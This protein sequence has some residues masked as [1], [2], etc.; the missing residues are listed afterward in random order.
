MNSERRNPLPRVLV[1]AVLLAAA[2][3]L[4]WHTGFGGPYLDVGSVRTPTPR[5]FVMAAL[6]AFLGIPFV[7]CVAAAA[8][9]L[10]PAPRLERARATWLGIPQRSFLALAALLGTLLPLLL[11]TLLLDHA[12]ITDDEASYRF[13]AELLASGHLWMPSPPMKLFYDNAFLVND[14]KLRSQYFLGWPFL[15]A[16]GV[17]LGVPSLINPL[18]SGA[19]VAGVFLVARRWWGEAWARVAAVLFLL[20]PFLLVGAA[21]GMSHPT[22]LVALVWLLVAATHVDEKASPWVS[23]GAALCI[24]LA[25]WA[26]PSVAVG[27]GLPF[28]VLW[29]VQAWRSGARGRH[30]AAFAAVALPLAAL[31]LW[32]NQELNGSPWLTGYQASARYAVANGFRFAP[33]SASALKNEGFLFFFDP[34]RFPE[35]VGQSVTALFR[36]NVDA[37]GWPFSLALVLLARSRQAR[38]LAAAVVSNLL[39]HLPVP[40]AG[41]DSFGPVHYYEL[42]LPVVLLSTDGLRTLWRW[43]ADHQVP[44]LAPAVLAGLVAACVLMYLPPRWLTLGRLVQ[45]INAPRELVER[46]APAGAVIFAPRSMAPPCRSNPA[47]HFVFFRPNSGPGFDDD[48]LWVNH[49]SLARN[50]QFMEQFPGRQG[51]LLAVDRKECRH[52]L[53]PLPQATPELF[54]PAVQEQPTDN[55]TLAR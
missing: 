53:V 42:M 2:Y 36:L 4:L 16:L 6:M 32:V 37:F 1:M 18:L 3:W 9:A 12:P 20:S 29:A 23:A 39:V 41:I 50:R 14:G 51:F 8:M 54:P 43:G 15:L 55:W 11:W 26:R 19:S 25:F 7:A 28:V 24:C 47:R 27:V 46:E 33:F 44:A 5:Y 52:Q 31:F 21:T 13:Q 10:L 22:T 49:V 45:D 40:D 35:A 17:K 30:A 38:W 34:E 48:V